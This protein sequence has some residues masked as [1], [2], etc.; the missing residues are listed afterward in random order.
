MMNEEYNY[1][2]TLLSEAL[3]LTSGSTEF[4]GKQVEYH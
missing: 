2:E 3:K 4:H 1:K